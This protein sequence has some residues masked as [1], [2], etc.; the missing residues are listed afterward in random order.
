MLEDYVYDIWIEVDENRRVSDRGG[1]SLVGEEALNCLFANS[2]LFTVNTSSSEMPQTALEY[3]L[4]IFLQD[5][6]DSTTLMYLMSI[7]VHI[8]KGNSGG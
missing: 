4:V 6:F 7:K 1:T 8:N 3:V 5:L 2:F